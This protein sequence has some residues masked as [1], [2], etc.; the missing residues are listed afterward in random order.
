MKSTYTYD[1]FYLYDEITQIVQKYAAEHP[2]LCRLYSLNKTPEGRDIWA[3]D[4][5]NTKTGAYEDKPAYCIDANIHAGEVTGSMVAMFFLDTIFSNLDDPEIQKILDRYTLYVIPRIS[6]DGSE[7]Y[8]TTPEMVRSVNRL[9]PYDQ[10]MPGLQPKDMDG[11]GLILK[12]RVKSPYGVWKVSDRDP[13]LMT[14]RQPDDMEGE[15][16][17]V[18]SEGYIEDYDG[19]TIQT[20][21]GKWGNDLNRNFP[22]SW[23]PEHNQRGA[24]EYPLA[25]IETRSIAEFI[26]GHKNICSIINLHTMTGVY[27]YPPGAKHRNEAPAEDMMRYKAIGKMATEET[28]YPAVSIIEEYMS[29]GAKPLTGSFDDFN[30]SLMGLHNYTIECWDLNPRAGIPLVFPQPG[31]D[32][33]TDEEKEEQ[34]YKYIQWIDEQNDGVGFKPWTK[35]QHPQLGEVEIGGIDYKHVVQNPPIK[36][37]R[38]EIEK[39]TRFFLRAIKTLPLISFTNVKAEHVDGSVYRV[40]AT[41]MN[42]GYLPTYV[43]EEANRAQISRDLKVSLEG[44]E[45]EL[46]EGKALQAIGQL[47]GF[48]G[49]GAQ[50]TTLGP[51]TGNAL[52]CE[53]T[54]S[55]VIK[56][57]PGT[58]LTL[59]A[60]NAKVGKTTAS[61]TL[62]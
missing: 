59:T 15:F 8:L 12:M 62:E 6:P 46:I 35:F 49:L 53:K 4:I 40:E 24:G 11:D 45:M 37:L 41:L 23:T 42:K 25:N 16:Y 58:T 60:G 48:S 19:H 1:H 44:E 14:K 39:H 13:R 22:L 43:T 29:R 55:W 31:P 56:A 26:N 34:H 30:Y 10:L 27:L 17:N 3:M 28:T 2:E 52:P 47:N 61:I 32:D 7:C 54:M 33:L 36:F 9:Y 20:A 5:T 21:P 57:A 38:Q 18:Y 51:A 50:M